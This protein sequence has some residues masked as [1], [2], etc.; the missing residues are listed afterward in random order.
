MFN[1][2]PLGAKV[3]D[4]HSNTPLFAVGQYIGFWQF[5]ENSQYYTQTEPK[6]FLSKQD[7]LD[8]PSKFFCNHHHSFSEL[9]D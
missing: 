4:S 9:Q 6:N 1:S 5:F 7:F 8:E 3:F 2:P